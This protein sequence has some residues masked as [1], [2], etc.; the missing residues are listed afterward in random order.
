MGG[1]SKTPFKDSKCFVVLLF[2]FTYVY[3]PGHPVLQ[4]NTDPAKQRVLDELVKKYRGEEGERLAV[5]PLLEWL[6]DKNATNRDATVICGQKNMLTL[7]HDQMEKE[8]SGDLLLP[9]P[10]DKKI[11][12]VEKVAETVGLHIDVHAIN[13]EVENLMI[14]YVGQLGSQSVPAMKNRLQS[15]SIPQGLNRNKRQ[16]WAQ[17]LAMFQKIL[18]DN[19]S[20]QSLD[21]FNSV[22]HVLMSKKLNRCKKEH[23]IFFVK[24]HHRTIGQ[25]EVKAI[26][27]LQN[28]EVLKALE[29]LEGGKEEMLKVHGHLLDPN[30]SYLGI[31]CLPNLPQNL[32][33]TMCRHLNICNHCA[34]YI[35]V[36]DLNS[37]MK[38]LVDKHFSSGA[39]F[40][41]EPVWRDQYKKVTSRI[42]AMQHLRPP[43]STVSR[44][45]GTEKVVVPAFTEGC[46]HM[47]QRTRRCTL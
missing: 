3:F 41:D 27:D 15:L 42:L 38:S 19:S 9:Q 34:E 47:I 33:Q 30:W 23:D 20:L 6:A 29:Q 35:L 8:L 43:V 21:L 31:I 18:H 17:N 25:V 40:P 36:G 26:A 4:Q 24:P 45:A 11:A 32:K 16:E 7:I 14:Q 10:V 28:H 39:A 1:G 12:G 2:L 22:K 13:L 5:L 44:M 46:R 37:G